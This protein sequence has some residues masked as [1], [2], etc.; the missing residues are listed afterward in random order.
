MS[1]DNCD[2]H[3]LRK[4]ELAADEALKRGP[5]SVVDKT[6]LPPSGNIHD[7]WHPAPYWW[8]HPLRI[9]GLP[10]VRRDGKRVPGTRLYEPLSDKYD[11]TRLQRLFDDTFI[12]S[13]AYLK[14][15]KRAYANHA[16]NLVRCWFI[17]TDTAMNPHLEYAQVRL[18]HNKNRG[19]STGIIEWKDL[20]FFL[21]AVSFLESKGFLNANEKQTLRLWFEKYLHWLRSSPQGKKESL[22]L[23]NHGTYYDLQVLA[24]SN[25]LGKK[26]L[27]HDILQHTPSRINEQFEP[28]GQQPLELKR[29]ITAHY[30]CFNLQGWIHL[31]ELA[32]RVDVNLWT[33][34][35]PKKQSIKIAIEW[36]LTNLNRAWPYKQIDE[37]DRERFYPIYYAYL[38]YY[39]Y[40][41]VNIDSGSVP[42]TS[43]IKPIFYPHD[44]IRPFWQL[45]HDLSEVV[46][47]E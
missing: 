47:H 14:H 43:E 13:L 28:D 23:N 15:G 27:S 39:G 17:D 32:T 33:L 29:P 18:G 34:E 5:F 37:F 26:F 3:L 31:S 16:S 2:P 22:S 21:D 8:P 9:P 10:Y 1:T 42:N 4:L 20:Y 19:V 11:R 41:S 46:T 40:S 45:A 38:R 6:T 36:L 35:G 44:G 7:Y 24:I 30:C 25:Y 12:L